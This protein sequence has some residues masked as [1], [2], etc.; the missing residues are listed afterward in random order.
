MKLTLTLIFFLSGSVKLTLTLIFF[1]PGSVKLTIKLVN[2]NRITKR[3]AHG[4]GCQRHKKGCHNHVQRLVKR[5][6]LTSIVGRI[7]VVYI[8]NFN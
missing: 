4:E 7:S 1:L 5:T 8:L 2:K 3:I 6:T